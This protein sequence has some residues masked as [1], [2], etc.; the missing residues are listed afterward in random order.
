MIFCMFSVAVVP[1]AVDDDPLK[2]RPPEC[3]EKRTSAWYVIAVHVEITQIGEIIEHAIVDV[4]QPV[5]AQI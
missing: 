3:H 1:Q 4:G 2:R 5:I